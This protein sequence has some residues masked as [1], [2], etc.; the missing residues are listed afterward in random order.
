MLLISLGFTICPP[1][2]AKTGRRERN[3]LSSVNFF[4]PTASCVYGWVSDSIVCV[5]SCQSLESGQAN[6]QSNYLHNYAFEDGS[7]GL[8]VM[9]DDSCVFLSRRRI[10]DG[11]L[12][13]F[14]H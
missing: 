11:Q 13:I 14:S 2:T 1:L 4:L 7:P 10:L 8:V 3:F 5:D 9:G 12:D 6:K